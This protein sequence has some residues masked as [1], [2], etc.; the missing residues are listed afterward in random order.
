GC[1]T[2]ASAPA[3]PLSPSRRRIAPPRFTPPSSRRPPQLRLRLPPLA[4]PAKRRPP[5]IFC[6][7][8]EPARA[9]FFVG[10]RRVGARGFRSRY[11]ESTA[12]VA[13][14]TLVQHYDTFN[15]C[16]TGC[17]AACTPKPSTLMTLQTLLLAKAANQARGLAIDAVH[18]CA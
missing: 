16:F 1:T 14:A 12:C 4:R 9:R 6:H 3:R 10:A 2:S 5:A 15:F 7:R 11:D 18:A 13:R 8:S 17:R